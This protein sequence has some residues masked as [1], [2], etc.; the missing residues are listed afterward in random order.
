MVMAFSSAIL[1]IPKPFAN[2]AFEGDEL[3]SD[4]SP[5]AA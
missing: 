2:R 3:A 4:Q 1:T 5:A